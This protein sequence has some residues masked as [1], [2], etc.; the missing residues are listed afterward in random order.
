MDTFQSQGH[1][2]KVKGQWWLKIYVAQ[3]YVVA[4]LVS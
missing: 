1:N 4:S 3:P 2:S